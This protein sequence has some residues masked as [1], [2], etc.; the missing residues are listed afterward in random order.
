METGTFVVIR[1]Q[2]PE[3][4]RAPLRFV[5]YLFNGVHATR[6]ASLTVFRHPSFVPCGAKEEISRRERERERRAF[7]LF[8]VSADRIR[9]YV[10]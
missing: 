8:R 1:N 6:L 7:P 10:T 4:S 5:E 2:Q 3:M 9:G